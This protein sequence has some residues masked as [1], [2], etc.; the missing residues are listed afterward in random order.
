MN[1]NDTDSPK[2]GDLW[3]KPARAR[4]TVVSAVGTLFYRLT[5]AKKAAISRDQQ[6]EANAAFGRAYDDLKKEIAEG[7][8]EKLKMN[9]DE[10]RDE[11]KRLSRRVRNIAVM[12]RWS[13]D[14]D[15]DLFTISRVNL[16][17]LMG[18]ADALSQFSGN[19]HDDSTD[20][21]A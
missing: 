2:N 4:S 20:D 19:D 5:R 3:P 18:V 15:A 14:D 8:M 7:P 9:E 13:N 16:I 21:R 10:M 6:R 11:A 17:T 1:K 12:V